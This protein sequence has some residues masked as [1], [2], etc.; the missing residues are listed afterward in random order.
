LPQKKQT[1]KGVAL[2]RDA[3]RVQ[4]AE[5]IARQLKVDPLHPDFIELAPD[6][7]FEMKE[8]SARFRYDR[9]DLDQLERLDMTKPLFIETDGACSG[10]P[11]PGGW[12]FI[13]AQGNMKWEM[14]GSEG[15]TSNNEMELRAIDEALEFLKNVIES[16]SEGC[17][18]TM[19]GRGEQ[20][21]ADNYI[22]LNGEAVKNRALASSITSKLRSINVEFRKVQGHHGDQWNDAADA[23]AV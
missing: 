2:A 16:D 9:P 15:S 23:L 8:L 20:W 19:I 1:I 4:I 18:A 11:G 10:N 22:R 7:R 17:I 5:L 21:E 12:G 6:N 14:Y 13:V 3:S